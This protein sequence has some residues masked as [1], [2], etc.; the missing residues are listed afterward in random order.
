[1]SGPARGRRSRAWMLRALLPCLALVAWDTTRAV[2]QT[3]TPDLFRPI[4][5]GLASPQ[6]LPLRKTIGASADDSSD[7]SGNDK[8]NDPNTP[9]PSRIGQVPSYGVAAANG[10][11]DTGFDSLNRTRKKPKPH[12]GE[13]RPRPP[14][15]PGSPAP[16]PPPVD[17]AGSL[18][19]SI[20]PPS[21]PT[22]HR[23]RRRWPAPSKASHRANGSRS[24]TIRSARSAIRRQ[25]SD[26]VGGRTQRRLRHQSRPP[27]CA[28]GRAVLGGGAGISRG[29]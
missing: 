25:L 18:R 16:S 9:A 7:P 26:Q 13:A 1:M 28:E 19:L 14:P 4:P 23:C 21:L 22:R 12:P 17:A 3:P 8:R 29:I 6:D 10:A 2:A 5:D 27:P 20:R 15:G 24:M 11:S